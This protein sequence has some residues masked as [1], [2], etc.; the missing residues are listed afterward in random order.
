[1]QRFKFKTGLILAFLLAVFLY[2]C[3]VSLAAD[4][5]SMVITG[6]GPSAMLVDKDKDVSFDATINNEPET[7]QE[8]TIDGPGWVWSASLSGGPNGNG[9]G[10]TASAEGSSASGTVALSFSQPGTYSVSVSATARYTS[11]CEADPINV[12]GNT[13]FDVSVGKFSV[14]LSQT[15]VRPNPVTVGVLTEG[16]LVA[17]LNVPDGFELTG[18]TTWLWEQ[19]DTEYSVDGINNWS[20]DTPG[21][22]T[23]L[24]VSPLEVTD[25]QSKAYNNYRFQSEGFYRIKIKVIANITTSEGSEPVKAE[26]YIG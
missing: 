25:Y 4:P 24:G 1:M 16:K 5:P 3:G 11:S 2:N 18:T 19:V 13:S 15:N 8:C 20:S 10:G 22:R 17:D 21:Y 26:A 9:E 6:S 7:N 12:S 23:A 14:T